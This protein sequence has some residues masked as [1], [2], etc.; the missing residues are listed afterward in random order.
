MNKVLH[1][2]NVDFGTGVITLHKLKHFICLKFGYKFVDFCSKV[3][4]TVGRKNG[5]NRNSEHE[6]RAMAE[7]FGFQV[8]K[9]EF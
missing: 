7:G 6:C 3:C 4:Y 8:K 2:G 1:N 9:R 5:V